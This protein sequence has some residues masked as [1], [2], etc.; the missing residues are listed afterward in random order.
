MKQFQSFCAK[1]FDLIVHNDDGN[2]VLSCG[3]FICGRCSYTAFGNQNIPGSVSVACP[4]CNK[5]K[6]RILSLNDGNL[7]EEVKMSMTGDIKF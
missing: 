3:D 4:A 5:Q 1:C 6:L 7:P 2:I